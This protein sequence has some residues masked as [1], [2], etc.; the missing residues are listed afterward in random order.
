MVSIGV[1][2]V[3]STWEYS[4]VIA[5][6][7][8]PP[9]SP[10]WAYQTRNRS[11]TISISVSNALYTPH[12]LLNQYE[13]TGCLFDSPYS[14][15]PHISLF[16][17]INLRIGLAL[18]LSV[19]TMPYTLPKHSTIN[20]KALAVFFQLLLMLPSYS[21]PQAYQFR[22][23]S[24]TLSICVSHPLYTPQTLHNWWA[25]TCCVFSSCYS[26]CPHI[27]FLEHIN[28]GIGLAHYLS[29]FQMPYTIPKHSRINRQAMVFCFPVATYAAFIFPSSS[30]SIQE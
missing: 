27:S 16:K 15:C 4:H 3:T 30:I 23:L 29:M 24:G 21:P 18:Y 9:Y 2:W 8:Y 11:G 7:C 25:S 5:Y 13:T 20:G 26:Y 12:T 14:C 10:Y 6:S 17:L 1:G 22:N 28:S 19:F